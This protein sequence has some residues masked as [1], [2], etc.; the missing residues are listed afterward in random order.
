MYTTVEGLLVKL[1][2]S[3]KENNPFGI[4]DSSTNTKYLEFLTSI[5]ELKEF[6][7]GPFT[8]IMDDAI[9]NCFIYNPNAPEADPQ[10][11]IKVYERT[12]EQNDELGIN[13]MNV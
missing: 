5:N 10:I 4:G 3:L 6:K 1:H 7:R 11:E 13:D 8:I 2:D 9:S 12:E